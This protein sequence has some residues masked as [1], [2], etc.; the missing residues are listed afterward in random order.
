MTLQISYEN[1]SKQRYEM[2][3]VIKKVVLFEHQILNIVCIY[4]YPSLVFSSFLY[5]YFLTIHKK[6][7]KHHM[8]MMS[9]FSCSKIIIL[10][11]K[12]LNFTILLL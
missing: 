6:N 12:V 9:V 7:K 5:T 1:I 8:N 10:K 2:N 4:F 11:K 3:Y